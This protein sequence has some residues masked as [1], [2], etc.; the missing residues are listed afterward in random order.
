MYTPQA[1]R[2][3][4]ITVY[5]KDEKDD[6]SPQELKLLCQLARSMRNEIIARLFG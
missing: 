2:V 3:D 4:L 1:A 5:S 6:L